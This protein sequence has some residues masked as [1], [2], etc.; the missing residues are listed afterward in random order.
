MNKIYIDTSNYKLE[1]KDDSSY[2][3]ESKLNNLNLYIEVYKNINSK[4]FLLTRNSKVN[5]E[6]KLRDNSNIIINSLGID[7]SISSMI[8]LGEDSNLRFLESIISKVDTVNKIKITHI[9]KNS[10]STY[11]NNGVNLGENKFYFEV[12]GMI[13]KN[14]RGSFLEEDSIIINRKDGD[15]K[16]IP[17]LIVDNE[18]VTANHA[19]FIGNFKDSDIWYLE[20]RGIN[21]EEIEK[22]LLQATLLKGIEEE[23]REEFINYLENK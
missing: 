22:L 2:F 23:N 21:Q 14:S 17:N 3:L 1:I 9:G 10:H 15:S 19:A 7:A 12:D 13:T 18:D 20:S 11:I 6:V 8:T 5:I 4:V 16:I